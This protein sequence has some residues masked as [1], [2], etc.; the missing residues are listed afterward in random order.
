MQGRPT[1]A[2]VRLHVRCRPRKQ[3]HHLAHRAH[4][5]RRRESLGCT[6]QGPALS[7]CQ[8]EENVHQA[9]RRMGAGRLPCRKHDPG[10]HAAASVV[11]SSKDQRLA[12]RASQLGGPRQRDDA[13]RGDGPAR[14]GASRLLQV[15]RV[16]HGVGD[17]TQMLAIL[18]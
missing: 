17:F 3:R 10:V 16:D 6:P 2:R 18:F 13:L 5:Y 4:H 12:A 8:A 11:P 15:E 14:F 1:L 7:R 9:Q